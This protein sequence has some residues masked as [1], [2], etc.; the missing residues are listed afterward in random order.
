[1]PVEI[2]R[3]FLVTS[4]EWR[5]VPSSSCAYR[6]SFLARTSESTVRV[7]RSESRATITVKG[8][9]IGLARDEFEYTVPVAHADYMLQTMCV[10]PIIEKVRHFVQHAGM[11]WEVDVYGGDATGLVLAEVEMEHV[12][13]PIVLPNWVG[14]DVTH[15]P[16]FRSTGISQNQWRDAAAS[17]RKPAKVRRVAAQSA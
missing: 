9:R 2:E 10:T 8:P 13:Q 11:T 1:M 15:D 4:D 17:M 5:N 16:R 14:P 6:Q 12:L 3:R 7:R